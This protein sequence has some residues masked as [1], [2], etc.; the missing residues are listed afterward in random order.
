MSTFV[1]G[2]LQ[3]ILMGVAL[4]AGVVVL[5]TGLYRETAEDGEPTTRYNGS[6]AWRGLI[7]MG[8]GMFIAASLGFVPAG[9]RGVVFSQSSGV[10][11]T[12]RGEGLNVVVP[13][14]QGIHNMNVRTQV[15][16]YESFVQ[17]KDLQ[18]VTLPIAINFHVDPSQSAK[19]FQ[20]VGLDYV[21]TIIVPAAFQAATE[22]AGQIE[23]ASIAISRAELALSIRQIITDRIGTA[24]IVVELVSVKD[25][26]FDGEFIAAVKAKVIANETAERSLRLVEVSINEAQQAREEASGLADAIAI[27]GVGDKQ[28]IQAI[29]EA[30][31]FTSEEYLEYLRLQV[32]DGVLPT[33]ILG[34]LEDV[35][36][37]IP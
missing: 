23:A 24:G 16:E 1:L 2:N 5:L 18:E 9:H 20:E 31:G 22:A 4:L 33:T 10:D 6:R 29:A 19:L 11:L 13:F 12:P 17:T 35:I 8:V 7:V 15:Y 36:V 28:A 34:E 32:W 25:A 30:L 14:W 3:P 21:D 26:V 37:S 27:R